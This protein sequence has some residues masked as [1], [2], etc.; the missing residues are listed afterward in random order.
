MENQKQNKVELLAPAG[1][2]EQLEYALHFGADAVYLAG[3][4]FGLRTRA[5]NFE[6]DELREAIA[7]VRAAQKRI[8]VTL[9]ALLHEDDRA[10]LIEFIKTLADLKPDA[11]IVSDL[12]VFRLV[13]EHAPQIKIHVSTQAS[14]TNAD[15]ALM[16]YELGA[17]R[18]VLAREVSLAD[19]RK[20]RAA[21]PDDLELETFVHGAMCMAHSGRCLIS[22]YLTNRDANR[23]SCTQPCR[24]NYVLME[25]TRPGRYIPVEEDEQGTYLMDSKDLKM[26]EHLDELIDAGVNSLK[27]E[28]RVKGAFYVATV[29]NAYSKVLKGG[30]LATYVAEL[31]TIS[32]RPYYTGFFFGP[33]EQ[34]YDDARYY[35]TH[36]LAAIVRQ[37]ENDR[38]TVTQRNRFFEGDILEVLSPHYEVKTFV[39]DELQN[40]YGEHVLSANKATEIYSM[41]A[42]RFELRA[43]DIIRRK[44]E[45]EAEK[46]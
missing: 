31:E 1:G 35:Q 17:R 33:A 4:Q 14:V 12:G 39:C 5:S 19:I 40:E 6:N 9:N 44:R 16:W 22:N 20:I 10:S 41:M 24:W 38:L 23:G 29:V 26:L 36:D 45:N 25:E 2:R 46:G 30:D 32:H 13:R 21:V 15:S 42:P 18:I 7:Y 3:S 34:T 27:I 43:G 11:V 37:V 8:Y 28:G